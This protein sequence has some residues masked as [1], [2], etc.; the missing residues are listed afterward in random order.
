MH[1]V[2]RFRAQK[3]SL[4][5]HLA[6]EEMAKYIQINLPQLMGAMKRNSKLNLAFQHAGISEDRILHIFSRLEVHLLLTFIVTC[7][8]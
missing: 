4:A 3:H 1:E 8:I 5:R 2:L 7:P 6:P